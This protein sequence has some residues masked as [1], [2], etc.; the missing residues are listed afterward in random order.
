MELP[1]AGHAEAVE[2]VLVGQCRPAGTVPLASG[3]V[4]QEP[5][6]Q[7]FG[8]AHELLQLRV[9]THGRLFKALMS[10]HVPGWREFEEQR[11]TSRPTRG[12]ARGQ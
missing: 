3:L 7:D 1:R 4:D 2:L 9:P 6:F 11:G 5:R 12:G 10:A 8:L